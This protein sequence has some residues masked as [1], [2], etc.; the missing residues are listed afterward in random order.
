MEPFH[1]HG[2]YSACHALIRDAIQRCRSTRELC[3][4]TILVKS[5]G[6]RDS[7]TPC[8]F[9]VSISDTGPGICHGEFA[10]FY[11]YLQSSCPLSRKTPC[12]SICWGGVL[13]VMT[14]DF[15]EGELRHYQLR[16]DAYNGLPSLIQLHSIPKGSGHFSGTEVSLCAAG[17]PE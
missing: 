7:S 1:P 11:P 5:T 2:V 16:L 10:R 14:T 12:A 9:Q 8:S 13:S 6:T 17:P 4:I 15:E 3:R